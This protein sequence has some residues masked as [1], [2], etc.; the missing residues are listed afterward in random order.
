MQA[1]AVFEMT[2]EYF[3]ES[4]GEWLSH[5][6]RFRKWQLQI[7]GALAVAGILTSIFGGPFRALGGV[8]VLIAA[9]EGIEFHWYRRQWIKQ[10]L[11]VRKYA[12]KTIQLGFDDIGIA[13]RGPTASGQMTWQAVHGC[14]ETQKGI[15]MKIGDGMSMYVPKQSVSPQSAVGEIV[16][17]ASR[18]T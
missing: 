10:R 5:R 18:Q 6:S 4:F 17:K 13:V 8:L 9:V 1:T 7:A 14:V 12:T 2:P 11:D 16:L 3:A 15:F